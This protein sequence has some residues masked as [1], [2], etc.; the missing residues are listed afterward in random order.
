MFLAFCEV[1][2]ATAVEE[3]VSTGATLLESAKVEIFLFGVAILAYFFLFGAGPVKLAAPGA[4]RRGRSE[5]TSNEAIDSSDPA[6]LCK[7]LQAAYLAGDHRT[8]MRYWNALKKSSQPPPSVNLGG[9]VESMQRFWKDSSFILKELRSF[10]K[11][12]P[13]FA[14]IQVMNDLFQQ[15]AKRLDLDLLD[16]LWQLFPQIDVVPD[17]RM[18]EVYLHAHFA[19]RGFPKVEAL[20]AEM[21]EKGVTYTTRARLTVIKACLKFGSFDRAI[22]HFRALRPMWEPT[23]PATPSPAPRHILSQIVELACK[24]RQLPRILKELDGLV[25]PTEVIAVMLNECLRAKDVVVCGEVEALARS[26]AR[27]LDP[28]ILGQLLKCYA[29]DPQHSMRIYEEICERGAWEVDVMLAVI[30]AC[31]VWKDCKH[32]RRMREEAKPNQPQVLAALARL[33]CEREQYE[34]VCDVFENDMLPL[35]AKGASPEEAKRG[36]MIDGRLERAL[37][38]AALK[39]NRSDLAQGIL[40]H[41][42]A[43]IAKHVTMIR[44][45]SASKNLEGAKTVF[46][47]LVESGVELNPIVYNAVLD[48][49]VECGNLREAEQWMNRMQREQMVDAV[50]YNTMIKAHLMNQNYSKARAMMSKMKVAGIAPNRVTYN[51]LLNACVALKRVDRSEMWSIVNEMDAAGIK[52]NHVTSSILLKSLDKDSGN[53]DVLR[54]MELINAGDEPM[55]EVL[56]SSVVE[57]CVRIGK[58]DLLASKLKQL[59]GADKIQ[60]TGAHTFGSLIKAYGHAKDVEGVWR[61]WREMRSRHIRPTAITLGCMVEAVVSNGDV[62]GGLEV[63]H[64]AL[65]DDQCRDCINAVVYCSVLKGFARD[66]KVSRVFDVYQEMLDKQMDFS[67]I[68]YNTL[69]DACARGGC[70]DRVP[71]LL[72]DMK[73]SGIKPNLITYSTML[74]GHCQAGDVQVAFAIL[75]QMKRDTNLKPD[76]IMYNSLLDGCAQNGL[77]DEG[78]KV[79]REMEENGVRPSNF[80]LSI[81]VKLMNRARKVDLAFNLVDELSKKYRLRPN[82]HVYTNFI[83]ACVYNRQ[84]PRAMQV[85]EKMVKERIQLEPRSYSLLVR[86]SLNAGFPDQAC[87]ILRSGLGLPGGLPQ[88]DGQ[89]PPHTGLEQSVTELLNGLCDQGHAVRLAQ[90]LLRDIK[91]FKNRLRVDPQVQR[92]VSNEQ[93]W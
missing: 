61:C 27:V 38:N 32:A 60:V 89:R 26:Q 34:D 64:Q 77:V 30:Q 84:F 78:Q 47:T 55:D 21:D 53:A 59:Q 86:G 76:E 13:Q 49:C 42:A 40:Q 23:A 6:Q 82:V 10:L 3:E 7:E 43:D 70:M 88:L 52:P 87:Q 68:T 25:V 90:P 48:A 39:C 20:M 41:S 62:E 79:L 2:G 57:A 65:E 14:E 17:P 56:L 36:L 74:K 81:V 44:S 71:R 67:V 85:M 22:E 35:A 69:V 18:Y 80:T 54:T 83:Q 91:K 11:I 58:P 63:V 66:R 93:G 31:E 15:V 45:C 28:T 75:E 51:E 92:R 33:Y 5:S 1:A 46:E 19:V 37:L 16:R 72:E 8:V 50:S 29:S 12:F 9:V 73:K 4:P 24:E